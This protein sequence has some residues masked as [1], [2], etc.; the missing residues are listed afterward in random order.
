M[1]LEY[2]DTPSGKVRTRL[3]ECP[4]CGQDLRDEYVARHIPKCPEVTA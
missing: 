4:F 1:T 3:V 2:K